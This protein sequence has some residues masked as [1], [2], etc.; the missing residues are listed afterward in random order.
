MYFTLS[1]GPKFYKLPFNIK[2][3]KAET[4]HYAGSKNP[5]SY[6]SHV[7]VEHSKNIFSDSIY[8]NNILNYDG[9]RFYQASIAEDDSFTVLSVNHDWLG[10]LVSYIG[11][12]FMM[13]GMIM[14]S[15][16]KK[17]VSKIFQK[18]LIN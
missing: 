8:M 12:F 14:V 1:Y 13:L 9:Y 15:F 11:Y 18:D 3:D 6:K 16:H 10:T 5:S 7:T 17:L 2:L 4:V